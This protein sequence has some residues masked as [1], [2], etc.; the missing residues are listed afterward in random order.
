MIEWLKL[1]EEQ[2]RTSIEQASAATGLLPSA[3]EKDWWVTL[4]LKALFNGAYKDSMIFKGGTSLSKCFDLIERFSEDIDIAL[5]PEAIGLSHKEHPTGKEID[6]LR[7]Q[8]YIFTSEVLIKD[9]KE[10]LAALGVDLNLITITAEAFVENRSYPD[11]QSLYL[12]Y[13][14]LFDKN[15]YLPNVVKIEV[16]VR[17]LKEPKTT[18]SIKSILSDYIPATLYKEDYFEVK[19]VE[20][21][22]TFLEKMFLLH[23]EFQK[24]DPS[25]IRHERMSR[26]LYDLEKM[27]DKEPGKK[28]LADN[29][30]YYIIIKHRQTYT[31]IGSVDYKTH[32]K[33]TINI[34]PPESVIG[35]YKTDYET[36]RAVMIYGD[37][38]D[39][40]ILIKRL[41]ELIERF[42]P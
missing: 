14:T 28:A 12:S 34:I 24:P 8:G 18:V 4:T 17:S 26:H 23:E 11:P 13:P 42:R 7:K 22:R 29:E 30:L 16:G 25:K 35:A 32:D 19:A 38:L 9:L 41:E 5:A 1:N 2:R 36:M 40:E 15:E 21:H 3:I 33:A 31:R 6:A 20:P 27:M 39:F 10:A 37:T